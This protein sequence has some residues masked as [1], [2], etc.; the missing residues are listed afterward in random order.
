MKSDIGGVSQCQKGQENYE[1]F[2]SR[3]K[4]FYQYDFRDHRGELFTCVR[5]TLQACRTARNLWLDQRKE[6]A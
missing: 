6:V 5:P 3:G 1:T 4:T 2:R